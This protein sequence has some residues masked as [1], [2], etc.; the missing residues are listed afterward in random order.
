M[1]EYKSEIPDLTYFL[2]TA[3]LCKIEHL[4]LS[5]IFIRPSSND[6]QLSKNLLP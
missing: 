3:L 6:A 5:T 2:R 1:F 4:F